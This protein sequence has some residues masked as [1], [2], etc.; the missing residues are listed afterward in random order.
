MICSCALA[1]LLAV[2]YGSLSD[3]WGRKYIGFLS[4]LGILLTT[5]WY[6]VVCK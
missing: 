1:I 6:E 5:I 4:V 3:K 2:P